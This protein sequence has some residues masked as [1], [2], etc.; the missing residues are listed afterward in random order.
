MIKIL[1]TPGKCHDNR[2]DHG[3]KVRT[4]LLNHS[5]ATPRTLSPFGAF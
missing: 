2:F 4:F 1:H 3:V 5:E